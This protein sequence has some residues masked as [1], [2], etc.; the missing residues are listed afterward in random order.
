MSQE[1]GPRPNVIPWTVRIITALWVA[2]LLG[3]GLLWPMGTGYD[4]PTHVDMAYAYAQGPFTFRGPGELEMSQ[5]VEGVQDQMGGVTR[6]PP[7]AARELTPRGER[8]SLQEMGGPATG[9]DGTPNQMVQHPPMAYWMYAAVLS[10]PGVDSLPWDGQIWLLRL[11]SIML[12]APLPILCWAAARR[13]LDA[14]GVTGVTAE[15]LATVAALVPVSMPNL[16]RVLS[17]ASNDVLMIMTASVL[18]YL[19][20]RVMTGDLR[21]RIAAAVTVCLAVVL[22]TKVFAVFLVPVV[23]VAYVLGARRTGDGWRPM[24]RPLAVT[25]LGGAVGS[26]WWLR[27]LVVYGTVQINGYGEAFMLEYWG[28]TGDGD[29]GRVRDFPGLYFPRFVETIWSGIG[30][31]DSLGPG[32]PIVFGWFAL[33]AL[34]VVLAVSVR[35]VDR[36][37]DGRSR[38]A[39]FLAVVVVTVLVVAKTSLDSWLRKAIGPAAAQGRYIYHLVVLL[40]AFSVVGWGRVLR[41]EVLR[42]LA[43]GVLLAALW[44]QAISWL[45]ILRNWYGARGSLG[46][47]LDALLEWS[48]V[49]S[50]VTLGCVF[51]LPA[52][53]AVVATTA[54]LRSES[55]RPDGSRRPP[56]RSL[57]QDAAAEASATGWRQRRS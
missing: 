24:W 7:M 26:I 49:A 5:G 50:P 12:S 43:L 51:V 36:S 42:R 9:Q 38:A 33:A 4:E 53:L 52:V 14:E 28:V 37:R 15:R 56:D 46:S 1:S 22:W 41:P 2:L 45:V 19:L 57:R 3:A 8:P 32:A 30:L 10:L 39:L 11:V 55:V 27:N 48:P 47:A 40:S 44:T 18:L 31:G 25:A 54:V 17:S 13:L 21:M 35:P 29:D 6:K 34:G 23:L 16:S 20:C